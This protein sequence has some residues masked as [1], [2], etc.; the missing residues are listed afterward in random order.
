MLSCHRTDSLRKQKDPIDL[1][2]HFPVT[3]RWE[4][5]S[6][7][8]SPIPFCWCWC[9]CYCFFFYFFMLFFFEANV[10]SFFFPLL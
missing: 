10:V 3:V 1:T 4:S 2:S 6:L 8:S 7:L 5:Q 9:C